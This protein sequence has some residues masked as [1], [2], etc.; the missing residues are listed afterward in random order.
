MTRSKSSDCIRS[1]ALTAVQGS[2]ELTPSLL[3]IAGKEMFIVALK[4]DRVHFLFF[5]TTEKK[6]FTQVIFSKTDSRKSQFD[7][8][9]EGNFVRPWGRDLSER[10]C[11]K[12]AQISCE[13]KL[14]SERLY[15]RGF[16]EIDIQNWHYRK[17]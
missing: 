8:S 16:S 17:V 13:P 5:D 1:S 10:A 7:K 3:C 15:L 9:L 12:S 6:Y 2:P 11:K 4:S 14:P